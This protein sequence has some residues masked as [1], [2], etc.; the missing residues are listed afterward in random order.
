MQKRAFNPYWALFG[1][2]TLAPIFSHAL[3]PISQQKAKRKLEAERIAKALAAQNQPPVEQA[4]EAEE[5]INDGLDTINARL[6]EAKQR[7][8]RKAGKGSPALGLKET[9]V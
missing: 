2:A 6:R 8:A 3:D 1:A 4:K 5:K 9:L 7:A